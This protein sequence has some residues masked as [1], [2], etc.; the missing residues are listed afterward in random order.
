VKLTE[1]RKQMD[2][3]DIYRTFFPKTKEYTFFSA[4]HGTFSKND[5]II[6][7]KTG[8]NRYKNIEIVPCILSDHHAVRLIFNNNINNGKPTFTWKL[9]NTLLNDTLVKEGIKKEIKVLLEF[10]EKEATIYPKLWDTMKAF[11]R[12]KHI[13]LNASK[14][15]LERADTSSLKTHLNALEKKEANSPKRSTRHE[16]IKLGGE[17]NQVETRRTIQRINQRRSSFFEKINK[18]DKP[19]ARLTR[20]HRDSIQI[21]KIRNE[22]GD[23]TTDPEEIQ[24]TIRSLYKRLNLTKLE[25]L[26]EMDKFLDRY[27]VPNLN[28]D[29]VTDLNSPISP[30]EIEAVIIIIIISH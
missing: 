2:L 28:Q 13:D 27:Q 14:K 16:I 3:T 18:I 22:K 9:N 10:N 29:Q 15:K 30:K 23:I 8:L 11:L 12:G 5:H 6:G 26:D 20:G 24:N 17:I 7:H 19:L 25:N 4:P 21:N 1:V